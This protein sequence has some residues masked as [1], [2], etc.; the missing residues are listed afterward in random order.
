M[1]TYL[2]CL[3]PVL[4]DGKLTAFTLVSFDISARKQAE[5]EVKR[6]STFRESIIQTAAEGIC[7]CSPIP[8]FP[9]LKFSVWNDR[10]LEITGYSIEEVNTLGSYQVLYPDPAQRE[11]VS[12]SIQRVRDEGVR[13][14]NQ[15]RVITRKDG[16]KCHISISTSF[17]ETEAGRSVI[18][19]IQD[20]S[21]QKRLERQSAELAHFGRV[22][23]MGEMVATISHELAQP[24]SALSNHTEV[25][26]SRLDSSS[27][28][29]PLLRAS[30]A[31]MSQQV[32]RAGAIL[33]RIRNFVQN[34]PSRRAVCD[35]NLILSD[36]VALV[37][38]DFQQR[39]IALQQEFT[40]SEI[41][42]CV[43]QVQIQQVVV[44]LLTNAADAVSELD[45]DRRKVI[46]RSYAREQ[47]TGFQVE[48][49][50]T[51]ISSDLVERLFE[52]FVSSKS[53]GMGMGLSISK[54]I[55][56]DHQGTISAEPVETGGTLFNVSLP[57]LSKASS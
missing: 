20:N 18:L 21:A 57:T 15:E 45:P 16:S 10:M 12:Q 7:V 11:A 9:Y 36:S 39:G 33:K 28:E 24:L 29:D 41:P 37:E 32:D 6:M 30:V 19:L 22:S 27:A 2:C 49:Q 25:C 48:D 5:A 3:G 44:N 50:G 38:A 51:G 34:V 53:N 54:S 46:V 8:E 35:L 13:L 23:T 43:D 17:T 47:Q 52:P 26:T 14:K 4:S 56:S 1:S 55:V 42:T 40:A 31:N